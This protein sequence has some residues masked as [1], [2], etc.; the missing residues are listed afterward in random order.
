MVR[1]QGGSVSRSSPAERSSDWLVPHAKPSQTDPEPVGVGV[2]AEIPGHDCRNKV[3]T[4]P[5]TRQP[6]RPLNESQ[7]R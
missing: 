2:L 5:R 1:G 7:F 3:S 4:K 6:K